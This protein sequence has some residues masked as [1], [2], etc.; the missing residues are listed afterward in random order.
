MSKA[1]Y[2]LQMYSLRDITKDNMYLALSEV[3]KM[4]YKYI[5]FAGFFDYKSAQ[6]TEWL[7][8][9]GLVCTGTHTGL[10]AIKPE[11][12]QQTIDYHKAIGC[13]NLIVPGA[14]WS[15]REKTDE[16]IKLLN[17]AYDR[18]KSEGITLAY[19]NHSKEFFVQDYGMIVEDEL[20][21]RTKIDLEIDI[22][23]AY[24]AGIDVI[25][26]LNTYKNRIHILHI[27]D[28]IA[29]KAENRNM[30]HMFD[31]V[32]EFSLGMGK[33]PVKEACDWGKKNNAIMIVES[34]GLNPTGLE[35]VKRCIEFLNT[36]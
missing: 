35:E 27:K 22:F 31:D 36:I 1:E 26:F 33:A 29:T 21:R 28:G 2:G 20:I 8:E 12:I 19:H 16:N 17:W 30:E 24:N 14:D 11:T 10:D 18:L 32:K 15:S 25:E 13:K 4:G 34:E 7:D 3:A 9:L 6:I 5:E 23:W